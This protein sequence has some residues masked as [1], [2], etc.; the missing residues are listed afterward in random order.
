MVPSRASPLRPSLAAAPTAWPSTP[1]SLT[2]S[3]TASWAVSR[4]KTAASGLFSMAA[5]RLSSAWEVT[6]SLS[7]TTTP[8]TVSPSVSW[9]SAAR[10]IS[11]M[12]ISAIVRVVILISCPP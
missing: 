10:G 6:G 8:L 5:S 11:P 4:P 2:A 3:L 9:A 7:S 12:A 1:P